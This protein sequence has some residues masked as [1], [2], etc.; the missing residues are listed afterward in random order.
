LNSAPIPTSNEWIVQAAD[1]LTREPRVIS[2]MVTNLEAGRVLTLITLGTFILGALSI[3]CFA[4][5]KIKAREFEFS[6]AIWRLV[7]FKITIKSPQDSQLSE[8]RVMIDGTVPGAVR[9]DSISREA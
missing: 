5:Y 9:P 3:L 6:T 2:W 8:Q 7:S 1:K 4:A